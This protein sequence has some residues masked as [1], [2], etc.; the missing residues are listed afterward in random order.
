MIC[1]T[2]P[3]VLNFIVAEIPKGLKYITSP[4][5]TLCLALLST[6]FFDISVS[7][8]FCF[9]LEENNPNNIQ[10]IKDIQF[11]ILRMSSKSNVFDNMLEFIYNL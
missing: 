7:G 4:T 10:Q 9:L 11:E 1:T 8:L 2:L 3:I 6:I 5:F